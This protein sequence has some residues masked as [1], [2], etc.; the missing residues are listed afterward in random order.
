MGNNDWSR[1]TVEASIQ[2]AAEESIVKR[3]GQRSQGSRY[4]SCRGKAVSGYLAYW[5]ILTEEALRIPEGM[6]AFQMSWNYDSESLAKLP[7][8]CSSRE[9]GDVYNFS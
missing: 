5:P 1:G 8:R 4:P 6:L 9:C 7:F 2:T 3:K